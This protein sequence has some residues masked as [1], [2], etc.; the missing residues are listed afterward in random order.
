MEFLNR[1]ELRGH[2]GNV[3]VTSVADKHVARIQ[4]ATEQCYKNRSG[5]AVIETTW[6]N[7]SVWE[8]N[9][10]SDVSAIAKGDKLYVQGRIRNARYLGSDGQERTFSEVLADKVS[11]MEA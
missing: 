8:G 11:K 10:C 9:G 2:V 5:E 4:M 3:R 1:V 6:H 7:V